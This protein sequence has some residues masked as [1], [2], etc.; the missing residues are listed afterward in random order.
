M[1]FHL[2]IKTITF[3]V[4]L[5]GLISIAVL[6]IADYIDRSRRPRP[7]SGCDKK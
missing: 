6:V 5:V 1:D 4:I 7:R 2:N 3:V